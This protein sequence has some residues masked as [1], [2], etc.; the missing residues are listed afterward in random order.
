MYVMEVNLRPSLRAKYGTITPKEVPGRVTQAERAAN[1]RRD[2]KILRDMWWM[3]GT[4]LTIFLGG[5]GFW[6]LDNVYCST[7]RQWRHEVG[8]PWGIIS[9]FHGIWHIMTGVGAYFY[10]VWGI[11]LRHCLHERQEEYEL[12]WPSIFF[13]LPEIVPA[14]N[15]RSTKTNGKTNGNSNGH[16][17]RLNGHSKKT[18]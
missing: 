3:V 13:S 10:L 7:L 4:G 15:V 9:E 17:K 16:L 11:W 2:R 18:V 5:F 8:L 14:A 1:D 12:Y 6:N